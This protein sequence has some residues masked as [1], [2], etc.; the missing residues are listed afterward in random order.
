MKFLPSFLAPLLRWNQ[1]HW[2]AML[3]SSIVAFRFLLVFLGSSDELSIDLTDVAKHSS[4]LF[5][6]CFVPLAFIGLGLNFIKSNKVFNLVTSVCLALGTL[7]WLQGNMFVWNYGAFDGKPL[8]FSDY[9][10]HGIIELLIWSGIFFLSILKAPLVARMA[11]YVA[12]II[13]VSQVVGSAQGYQLLIEKSAE[14]SSKQSVSKRWYKD[15]VV[16]TND[17]YSFSKNKNV[18]LVVLDAGRSDVFGQIYKSMPQV[19]RDIFKGFTNFQNTTGI[20]SGTDPS[21]TG[22]FTGHL[23]DYKKDKTQDYPEM[24]YSSTSIPFQLKN[25]GFSVGMYPYNKSSVHLAPDITDNIRSI[26]EL[27]AAQ[28]IA[29]T[30]KAFEKIYLL[31]KFNFAPHYIK[32]HVYNDSS[33]FMKAAPVAIKVTSAKAT[34]KKSAKDKAGSSEAIPERVLAH[35]RNSNNISNNL[36]NKSLA[37]LDKNVFKY[38]HYHGAHP[39]F[40]H[41]KRMKAIILPYNIGS[42]QEQFHGA[43][44]SKVGSLIAG[45]KA[46]GVYD[47]TMIIVIG[48]HGIYVPDE[49]KTIKVGQ[50]TLAQQSLVPFLIVKPFGKAE[51]KM[52]VSTAP[53]SLLDIPATVFDALGLPTHNVGRPVFSVPADAKRKRHAYLLDLSPKTGAKSIGKFRGALEFE[54]DGNVH[55]TSSWKPTSFILGDKKGRVLIDADLYDAKIDYALKYMSNMK[56]FDPK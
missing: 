55:N 21:M 10:L 16:S 42:Y 13:I 7:L 56:R 14:Q 53:V 15:Y 12:L 24:F 36:R 27:S 49:T 30:R 8:N 3:I 32:K 11:K 5:L 19:E 1:F 37:K 22:V 2:A 28:K 47:N 18:I 6:K 35:I 9:E 20:F 31:A 39:P 41:N 38:L 34:K 17:V 48:D 43:L 4:I 40:F 26:N 50:S 25:E 23:Y 33:L 51:A 44:V 54:V 52:K 29:F 45:L 46:Q